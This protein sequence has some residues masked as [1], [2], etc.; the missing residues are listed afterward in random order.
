M[1]DKYINFK[2]EE[3]EYYIYN[4]ENGIVISNDYFIRK[5]YRLGCEIAVARGV[6]TCA[7]DFVFPK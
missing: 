7:V 6:Y 5:V 2:M 4:F 3:D 1:N